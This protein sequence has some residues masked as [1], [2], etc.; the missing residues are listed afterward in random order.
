M[1]EADPVSVPVDASEQETI[2]EAAPPRRLG[3][4]ALMI[5]LPLALLIGGGFYWMSLQGKVSTDN[6]YVQQDKVSVSAEVGG[7][8][9]EVAVKDGQTVQQGDL[10]FRIDPEP[11]RLQIQQADASI[12]TAQANVTALAGSADL[13]G[14]DLFGADFR[15]ADLRGA[16]FGNA[17]LA[18][19]NLT[20]A[21]LRGTLSLVLTA[22]VGQRAATA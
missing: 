6:A 2:T 11:Y 15:D 10:L 20:G 21:D 12:A 16:K 13:S 17:N 4:L 14:A 7:R 1:A 5:S 19:I 9:V 3:R 18:G 8:I 22:A